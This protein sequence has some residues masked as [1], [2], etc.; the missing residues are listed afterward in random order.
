MNLS[1][2]PMTASRAASVQK[3][4]APKSGVEAWLVEDYAVPLIAFNAAFQGGGAQDA[5][6]RVG[7]TASMALLLDEGA[8]S[9]DADAFHRALDEKA[10]E[11]SFSS[12]RDH[13]Q[14]R[15]RTLARN[16]DAAADFLRLALCEPRFDPDAIERARAQTLATLKQESQDPASL[17]GKAW[18]E[19]AFPNHPYGM[20]GRGTLDTVPLISRDDIVAQYM[21]QIARDGLKISIVGA[22]SAQ[23]AVEVLDHIFAGLPTRGALKAVP[24]VEMANAGERRV[25]DVDVPQSTIR[26]S[27]P[28]V[29]RG[30]PDYWPAVVV[31]H[32]LG[33]GVFSARLFREVRE[34]RGLAYSVGSQL[35]VFDHAA[36]LSGSTSTKNERAAESLM[37]IEEQIAE[38]AENGPTEDELIKARKYLTGSYALQF[39]TSTKIASN[40]TT[41][42][43]AGYPVDYLDKRNDYISAVTLEDAR[44]VAVRLFRGK[45]LLVAA[46]GRP[47]GL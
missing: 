11:I 43:C 26:F 5:V 17:S 27:L 12:D 23:S 28:G 36:V 47:V 19:A 39:D 34:K 42:Q 32:I 6:E 15:A 10:V 22:I 8:G 4:R 2:K 31:N 7:A 18:R 14:C 45:K 38:L 37:V 33:G 29:D 30:D 1:E 40:L 41:L 13:V 3:V 24:N 16:L 46:A 9:L 20:A 35:Q 25:I 21:A 44:R